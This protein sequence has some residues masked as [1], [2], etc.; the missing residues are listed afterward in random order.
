MAADRAVSE[1]WLL[2]VLPVGRVYVHCS[3]RVEQ[4]EVYAYVLLIV[5]ELKEYAEAE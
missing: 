2:R 5:A 3:R 4:L 1:L